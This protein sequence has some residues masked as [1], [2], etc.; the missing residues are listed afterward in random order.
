M[1][2]IDGLGDNFNDSY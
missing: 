1:F 2:L